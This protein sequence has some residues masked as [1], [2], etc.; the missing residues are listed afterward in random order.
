MRKLIAP[1]IMAFALA[2]CAQQI[3]E[4]KTAYSAVTGNIVT[5]QQVIIAA[6]AFDAIKGTATNYLRLPK[7]PA[8]AVCRTP[9]ASAQVIAAIRTGTSDRNQLKASLRSTP[10]ANLTLVAVYEDLRTSTSAL[11]ALVGM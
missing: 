1:I 10:G 3:A 4:F 9:S 7:C 11:A 2:G 8:A 5:P 6:N